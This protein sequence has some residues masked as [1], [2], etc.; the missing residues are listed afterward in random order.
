MNVTDNFQFKFRKDD[1]KYICGL[2]N[3]LEIDSKEVFS[4]VNLC[5]DKAMTED[6]MKLAIFKG[7]FIRKD[8]PLWIKRNS[9]FV[10]L[11]VENAES[12]S[13]IS[14]TINNCDEESLTEEI[15]LLAVSK[16]YLLNRNSPD[17]IKANPK[18]I[19]EMLLS[20]RVAFE[21]KNII[22]NSLEAAL[23]DENLELA[24]KKGY[25]YDSDT[26]LYLKTDPEKLQIVLYGLK[27][28]YAVQSTIN[29]CND[30]ALTEENIKIAASKGYYVDDDAPD[31]IKN[32]SRFIGELLKYITNNT[33]MRDTINH[34]GLSC[35]TE[36]NISLAIQKGYQIFFPLRKDVRN[37]PNIISIFLKVIS[38]KEAVKRLIDNCD[39]GALVEENV[40]SAIGKGY[41]LDSKTKDIISNNPFY[42]EA[43]LKNSKNSLEVRNTVLLA[44][45]NAL[46]NEVISLAYKKGFYSKREDPIKQ[47]IT[48]DLSY[49]TDSDSLRMLLENIYNIDS[50]IDLI[51]TCNDEVFTLDILQYMISKFPIL[52]YQTVIKLNDITKKYVK[53]QDITEN[54]EYRNRLQRVVSE[55][56]F[57]AVFFYHDSLFSEYAMKN[58]SF[59]NLSKIYRYLYLIGKSSNIES[60]IENH[61]L[62]LFLQFYTNV[63]DESLENFNVLD[64]DDASMKYQKYSSFIHE[65][66][67][68]RK[69]KQLFQLNYSGFDIK[70]LEELE[71]HIFIY[72][73]NIL[74]TVSNIEEIKNTI[75]LLL[76]NKSYGEIKRILKEVI[77]S[78]KILHLC[79]SFKDKS[80]LEL[81]KEYSL[82]VSFLEYIVDNKNIEQLK[83]IGYVLNNMFLEDNDQF[84][85]SFSLFKNLES[86]MK[87]IYAYESNLQLTKISNLTNSEFVKAIK[88]KYGKDIDYIDIE[89]DYYFLMHTMNAFGKYSKI[90]DWKHPRLVGKTFI[91]LSSISKEKIGVQ[92][93]AKDIDSVT[94][95]F[96]NIYPTSFLKMAE[97]DVFSH[98]ASFND[99]FVDS[100]Y[101]NFDTLK[102]NLSKTPSYNEYVVYRENDDGSYLYPSAI[103]VVGDEPNESEIEVGR[104][105]QIPLV[106]THPVLKK[107]N[108]VVDII[109]E[110][111]KKSVKNK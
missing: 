4:I 34:M 20:A 42:I 81:L 104:Y 30:T 103:L 102:E 33:W 68:K 79:N 101:C 7:Y 5:T 88:D 99:R 59:T 35:Y 87:K 93:E 48:K 96:D 63:L 44:K 105:L 32:N 23:T 60:L 51:L 8:A 54:L 111:Q 73:K 10:R 52:Q 46:T 61:T 24:V 90:S 1:S 18:V 72:N 98:S 40:L 19:R 14:S 57:A 31:Y 53:L 77:N 2:L 41:Y 76:C 17:K 45:D 108:T 66:Q 106:K 109:N 13:K 9:L 84:Q 95:L 22:D 65:V 75:C 11:I 47:G 56:G 38:D 64:F 25:Y 70:N 50:V 49:Q 37:D 15:I 67:D 21:V 89:G 74:D 36:E 39:I 110:E 29:A 3:N 92:R 58:L 71:E 80:M 55:L 91:S 100:Q 97:K 69:I 26:P 43:L 85:T 107:E 82:V 83:E 28:I 27:D 86:E 6:N 94:L 78:N 12:K 16:G 62:H